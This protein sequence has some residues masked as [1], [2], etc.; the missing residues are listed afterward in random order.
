VTAANYGLDTDRTS[1]PD[2]PLAALRRRVAGRYAVDEFG[3]DPHLMDLVAPLFPLPVA[4][5][6]GERVPDLGPA[7]LIANRGLGLLEPLA[8]TRAVRLAAGRRTRVVGAPEL[9]IVGD[10]LRTLGAIGY[11]PDDVAAMLRA[12]HLAAAPLGP[13]WFRGGAGEPPRALFVATLGFPVL[14]VAVRPGFPQSLPGR[15]WRV[16]FGEPLGPPA[17]TR[18]GDQLAAAELADAVGEAVTGLLGA[19]A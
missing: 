15:R 5:E 9:P 3:A 13:T 11:R 14:P 18:S 10:A 1:T 17:G 16:R 2:A 6:H 4:I 7:L 12:G 19:G 8:V